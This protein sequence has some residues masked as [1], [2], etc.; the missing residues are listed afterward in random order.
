MTEDTNAD[1]DDGQARDYESRATATS[2][3]DPFKVRGLNE[4]DA[5]GGDNPTGVL[6]RTT[7]SGETYGIQGVADSDGDLSNSFSPVGVYGR[8]TGTPSTYGVRGETG[9]GVGSAGVLALASG[10]ANALEAKNTTGT[11]IRAVSNVPDSDPTIDAF[12]TSGRAS[13]LEATHS[14][15][16]P[17]GSVTAVAAEIAASNS[18][19]AAVEGRA[20]AESGST[21]GVRG[22][23]NGD[24]GQAYGVEGRAD[25]LEAIGIVASNPNGT[26]LEV[27]SDFSLGPAVQLN[28]S[29][30]GQGLEVNHSETA[31]TN[32]VGVQSLVESVGDGSAGVEGRA[33]GSSGSTTGVRGETR[34]LDGQAAGVRGV[35]TSG[36]ATGVVAEH[37]ADETALS[38]TNGGGTAPAVRVT[39]DGTGSASGVGID[40]GG[41][42]DVK[43][44]VT[45]TAT[46]ATGDPPDKSDHVVVVTNDLDDTIGDTAGLAIDFPNQTTSPDAVDNFVTFSSGG[47]AV[48]AIHGDD[49]G[50]VT[51]DTS[52]ADYAEFLPRLDDEPPMEAGEVVGVVDGSVTREATGAA[53]ALVVSD[54][55]TV[56]ANSPGPSTADREG[57]E[58]LAFTGQVPTRVRGPVDHGDVVVPSGENDG[59]ARAV[60]PD[61][62]TPGDRPIV[63]QAWGSDDSAGVAEVTV[64]VGI[65]DP[66]VVGAAVSE[67]RE[68]IAALER[69]NERLHDENERLRDRLS[70]LEDRVTA[71]AEGGSS[72][73]PADD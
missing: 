69:E 70:A 51:L 64:A 19:S 41:D 9:G 15:T 33:T 27:S 66:A 11:S 8:A 49:G 29:N 54:R 42:V 18:G 23:T 71:I 56:A 40:S 47:T 43:G 24:G 48:G 53:R 14:A 68:R 32:S 65:D 37:G 46:R 17:G 13:V 16:S 5:S 45:A 2:S 22:V 52:G 61:E 58:T 26:A 10:D 6:G 3:V 44:Q 20:T 38:V 67:D 36:A 59:T 63:G 7:G 50:G 35:A 25:D 4:A 1:G 60:D 73:A 21:T 57:H 30:G 28:Q 34:S 12:L 72:P 62:W 55:P 31:A 39:A